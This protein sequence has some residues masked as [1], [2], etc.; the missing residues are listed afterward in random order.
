MQELEGKVGKI[1]ADLFDIE[2]EFKEEFKIFMTYKD[3]ADYIDDFDM[4]LEEL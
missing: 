4:T 3:T 2:D 1:S